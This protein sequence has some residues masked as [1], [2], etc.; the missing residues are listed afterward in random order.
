LSLTD[1]Q[2]KYIAYELTR[3]FPPGSAEKLTAALVDAQDEVD[4]QREELIARIAGKLQQIVVE[5]SL[6][7]LRRQLPPVYPGI[8]DLPRP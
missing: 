4:R 1:Y 7:F 8:K 6:F 5:E 2:S 3:R